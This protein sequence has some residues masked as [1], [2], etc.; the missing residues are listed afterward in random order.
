[1]ELRQITNADRT[2]FTQLFDVETPK[3]R[4][5]DFYRNTDDWLELVNNEKTLA[6]MAVV[7]GRPV[8]FAD[9]ELN[10][11][12]GSSF[13]IGIAPELRGKGF[14]IKLLQAI[15]TFCH[16]KGATTIQAGVEKDNVACL[17]LLQKNGYAETITEDDVINFIKTL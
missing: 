6:L 8:G 17:S 4:F 12:A 11:M 1:M 10:D 2:F 16:D 15:E 7:R 3:N 14:G 13:A 5:I 9:V